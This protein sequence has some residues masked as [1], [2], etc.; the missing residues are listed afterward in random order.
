MKAFDRVKHL[1]GEDGYNT[2]K[3][4][5]IAIF[6]V[7]G[8]GGFVAEA[9]C[10]SGIEK[11]DIFDND[12]VDQTNIN[13]QIIA[14]N[15]TVSRH[16]VEVMK[17]RLLSINEE[18]QIGAYKIFYLPENA[19]EVDF[20]KYDYIVDAIDTV[21]SKIEI[22]RRAYAQKIPVISS[23]GTGGKLHAEKLTVAKI[24]D[25]KGCPLA[26]VIRKKLKELN[27][28]GVKVV[29]SEEESVKSQLPKSDEKLIKSDGKSAPPSMIF[30]PATAGLII[31]EQVVLDLV[32]KERE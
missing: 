17:E 27:I 18:A 7:G 8:V 16:K 3:N 13:R 2:L 5:K 4:S 23:M 15:H 22:I 11:I 31:A 12:V 14:T 1:L 21:T 6:G 24:E 30:V 26:R 28:K 29:Y 20:S 19:D 10:R 32:N 25:T 9:L